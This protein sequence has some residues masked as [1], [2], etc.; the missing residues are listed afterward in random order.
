LNIRDEPAQDSFL[1]ILLYR[2]RRRER[3]IREER[4]RTDIYTT[5]YVFAIKFARRELRHG[6][7]ARTNG[8]VGASILNVVH[9]MNDLRQL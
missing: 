9:G 7:I 4:K 8:K 3:R 6:K 5:E 2:R 1:A